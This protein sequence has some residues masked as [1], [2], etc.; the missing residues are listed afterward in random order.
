MRSIIFAVV[1]TSMTGAALSQTQ[2]TPSS[3]YATLPTLPSAFA[4]APLSPCY[5]WS[6][7]R[8]E[9]SHGT[10]RYRWSSYN[11]TSPCYSGTPYPYYSAFEPR[12]LPTRTNRPRLPGSASLNK[13]QARA[14]IEAKGY[15][16]VSG[17]VQDQR[18]VWRGQAT[19]KDGRPVDVI[20]DLEGDIYSE[21]STLY[22]RIERPRLKR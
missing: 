15:L 12:E 13:D 17:L 11:P 5:G 18:G 6:F 1:V 16:N 2:R 20:I 9:R 8:F 14:R 3:A 19:M 10:R 21:L 4:T 22:I 7:R